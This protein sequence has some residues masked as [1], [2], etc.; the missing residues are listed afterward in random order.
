MNEKVSSTQLLPFLG[1]ARPQILVE[2]LHGAR[3]AEIGG[4]V[5][6]PPEDPLGGE[7]P[8]Q[9]HGAAGVDARRAEAHLWSCAHKKKKKKKVGRR[10]IAAGQ[11]RSHAALTQSKAVAVGETGASVPEDAGAVQLLQE[12][13]R[14]AR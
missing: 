1:W 13:L 7:Q 12:P 6:F 2:K 10:G 4:R 3:L 9:A 14:C 8:L 5:A 11:Q